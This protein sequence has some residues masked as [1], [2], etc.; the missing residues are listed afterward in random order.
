MSRPVTV[1]FATWPSPV[2]RLRLYAQQRPGQFFT[3]VF[4]AA[5]RQVPGSAVPVL[6]LRNNGHPLPAAFRSATPVPPAAPPAVDE[7]TTT[8]AV[9]TKSSPVSHREPEV[10]PSLPLADGKGTAVPLPPLMASAPLCTYGDPLV[11]PQTLVVYKAPPGEDFDYYFDLN[12][13][14]LAPG[15]EVVYIGTTVPI[16]WNASGPVYGFPR[17]LPPGTYHNVLAHDN[18]LYTYDPLSG[19]LT[20]TF[21]KSKTFR[22]EPPPIRYPELA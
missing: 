16:G 2:A 21:A 3:A 6:Q 19:E 5:L 15:L 11:P 9:P 14:R 1:P 10:S 20:N 4:R 22:A 17:G 18:Y 8:T 12:P 7:K 13:P